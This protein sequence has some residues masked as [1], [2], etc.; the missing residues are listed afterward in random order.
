MI[1]KEKLVFGKSKANFI[2]VELKLVIKLAKY[3]AKN[4][5]KSFN[6]VSCLG[7]NKTSYM[8]YA[9]IKGYLE[10]YLFKIPFYNKNK[11]N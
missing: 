11:T 3:C 8:F 4:N 5:C 1:G 10:Y 2:N 9:K 6:V 7:A